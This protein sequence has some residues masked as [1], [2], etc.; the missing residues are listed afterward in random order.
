MGGRGRED[1]PGAAGQ[2][3]G[4]ESLGR[5]RGTRLQSGHHEVRIW[6]ETVGPSLGSH[7]F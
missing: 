6:M 3:G 1:L 4:D 5:C 2:A 7:T